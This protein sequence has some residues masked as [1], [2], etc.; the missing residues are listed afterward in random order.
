MASAPG[1]DQRG[2]MERLVRLATVL[3]HHGKQGVSA[4]RLIQV[5]GFEGGRNPGD[6]LIREFRHLRELGW[7]IENLAEPGEDGR[8]RMTS[9]D[10]RLR[11]R[12]TPGQQSALRRAALVAN[13]DDLVRRLG[14]P[15]VA[16][17]PAVG[18]PVTAT[19]ALGALSTLTRAVRQRSL[20][21]FRYSGSE[22]VV[23]PQAARA[24]QGTWYLRG[25]EDGSDLV[26]SF[27]VS[28]MSEVVADVPGSAV[29][30][31]TTRHSGLHPMTWELDPPTEVRLRAP[32]E[33]VDDVR[34]RL[35][36]PS[37]S[38]DLGDGTVELTY[39]VTN[40]EGLRSRLYE[41]GPRVSLVGPE[42]V[43]AEL[44]DELA[45]MAGE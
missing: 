42:D 37:G 5:A 2:P 43:R 33:Y 34:R 35:L 29:R 12:L 16:D 13:R 27:V 10:N 22:R 14:L 1:R 41:L 21:R 40:R 11:V 20:L 8:Y 45:E 3:H 7:E 44:L 4:E 24:V 17:V 39:V 19:A 18:E 32:A 9:I 6:Q 26:K 30:D 25:R 36:E 28:R 23:H 15:E 31:E 38:T